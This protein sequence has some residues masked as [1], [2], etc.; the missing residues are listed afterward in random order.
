MYLRAVDGPRVS[1]V[2]PIFNG[3]PYLTD[4][5][6]SILDQTYSNLDVVLVDGGSTDGSRQWLETLD[7]PRIQLIVLAA[8]TPAAV[9]WTTATEAAVGDLVKL[10]C[11]DD[12]LYPTAIAQ[13]V[14]DLI[15]QPTADVALAQRDV[16][17][18]QGATIY[19]NRGCHGLSP[20]VVNGD[21]VLRACYH[22]GTNVLGEPLA[23]MFR[24]DALMRAMPWRDDQPYLLDLNTY[25]RV[26]MHHHSR[27]VVRKTSIGAFRV[28]RTS[29][30]TRL[31]ASQF[32][33]FAS[34]QRAYEDR[35]P[36]NPLTRIRARCAL[37][38]QTATRAGAYAWLNLRGTLDRA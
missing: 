32:E 14:D 5:V 13:Q 20:G 30:S 27:V 10:V 1:V 25:T 28:S 15:A 7:D 38:G 21:V 35:V 29:W 11:H 18:A 37:A 19:R 36:T 26:L 2:V 12:V 23:L 33:Q 3:L 17:S 6:A 24:R 31:R 22:A 34:W 4:T 16:I 8:A 9:T